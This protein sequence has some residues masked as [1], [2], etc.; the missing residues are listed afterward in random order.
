MKKLIWAI[1][2][3]SAIWLIGAV[4]CSAQVPYTV[5]LSISWDVYTSTIVSDPISVTNQLVVEARQN[6][7]V[8]DWGTTTIPDC[9]VETEGPETGQCGSEA[10]VVVDLPVGHFEIWTRAA[11]FSNE[12]VLYYLDLDPPTEMDDN[13]FWLMGEVII[14]SQRIY[15]PIVYSA[16]PGRP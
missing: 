10:S 2:L 7:D 12:E 6:G 14:T 3:G 11:W 13:H 8:V 5:T 16:R 4:T 1:L 9:V 15:L